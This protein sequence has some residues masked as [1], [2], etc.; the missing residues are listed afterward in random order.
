MYKIRYF[1]N[2]PSIMDG[3]GGGQVIKDIV[4]HLA[5]SHDVKP[6]DIT[7]KVLDFDVFLAFGFTYLNPEVLEWY[8]NHSVKVICWPIFDRMKP[9]LLMKILKPIMLNLPVLNVYKQRKQVLDS[10]N[11]IIAANESEKRDF[12]QIYNCKPEVV[13]VLHYGISDEIIELDKTITKDL[14]LKKYP[15]WEDFVFCPASAIYPRKNQM[16]LIEAIKGTDIKLVLNNTNKVKGYSKQKFDEAT[17]NNPNIL[18]LE[19]MSIEEMVSCY[20]C[21]KVSISVSQ[22][23]TAGLVNLEAAYLGCNLVVSDLE[24]LRE[25]LGEFAIFVNQNSTK[26]ILSALKTSMDTAYNENTKTLIKQNYSWSFYIKNI[27]N[28]LNE[29]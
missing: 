22:A 11:V 10:A 26:S 15:G 25:Y 1:Y 28:I 19:R 6:L 18:C 9:L 27:E 17:R 13:K 3:G 7:S 20:K 12:I 24:A 5:L 21:A 4:E 14:F 23:E 16:K 2:F 29:I 8:K